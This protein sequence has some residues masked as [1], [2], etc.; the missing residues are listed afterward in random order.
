MV[1]DT[2]LLRGDQIMCEGSAA[3]SSA[4]AAGG[5]SKAARLAKDT[6]PYN[7]AIRACAEGRQPERALELLEQMQGTRVAL[8]TFSYTVVLDACATGALPG[9]A[10][11][12]L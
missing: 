9:R 1:L 10:Q 4:G 12:L 5:E 3:R 8:C 11:E 2:V 6:I 7:A